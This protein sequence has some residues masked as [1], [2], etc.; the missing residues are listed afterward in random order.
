MSRNCTTPKLLTR[1]IVLLWSAASLLGQQHHIEGLVVDDQDHPISA[2]TVTA[3]RGTST[4]VDRVT[5]G[6]DGRYILKYSSGPTIT[7]I[8]YDHSDWNAASIAE[9]SGNRDHIIN[10]VLRRV[11]SELSTGA[12]LDALTAY[13]AIYFVNRAAS[14]EAVRN[15][16]RSKYSD[17]LQ[18]LK[19]PEDSALKQAKASVMT[20]YGV[21]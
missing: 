6:L 13:H 7:T 8:I 17:S 5:T 12:A 15:A 19:V 14:S 2:V 3:Y 16:L 20:L 10:K 11:G 18:A 4:V 21:N 9:V 1:A